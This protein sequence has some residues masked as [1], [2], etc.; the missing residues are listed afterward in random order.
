MVWPRVTEGRGWYDQE[1]TMYER[2]VHE[3]KEMPQGPGMK[4]R[5]HARSLARTHARTHAHTHTAH[6]NI[7][8]PDFLPRSLSSFSSPRQPFPIP[9]DSAVSLAAANRT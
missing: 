8:S 2:A 1:D 7:E 9:P 5:T 3:K 4:A 6:P